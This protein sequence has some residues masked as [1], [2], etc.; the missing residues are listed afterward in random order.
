MAAKP[1]PVVLIHFAVACVPEL[2]QG[3]EQLEEQIDDC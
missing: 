1:K 2:N 3:F